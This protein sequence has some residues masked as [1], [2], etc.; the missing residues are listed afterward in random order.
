[1]LP[2]GKKTV[3]AIEKEIRR[4]VERALDDFKEDYRAFEL[5]GEAPE[6]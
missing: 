4:I 5:G 3:E 1:M 2:P 6:G